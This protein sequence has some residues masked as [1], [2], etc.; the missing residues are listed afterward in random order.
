[1]LSPQIIPEEGIL[2]DGIYFGLT[3]ER[4]HGDPALGSTSIKELA[5][6]PC[7]WQYDPQWKFQLARIVILAG[8]NAHQ[9]SPSVLLATGQTVAKD[10]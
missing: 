10:H 8:L 5:R 2:P 1:M 4:Y 9:S 6:K 7:K 3:E